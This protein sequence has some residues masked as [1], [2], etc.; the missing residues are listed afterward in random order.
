[1]PRQ[2]IP[3]E[4]RRPAAIQFPYQQN[5]W[6]QYLTDPE[7]RRYAEVCRKATKQ[8]TEAQDI[9]DFYRKIHLQST[10]AP[11]S[12]FPPRDPTWQPTTAST[13]S[14]RVPSIEPS[15]LLEPSTSTAPGFDDFAR[16]L[17]AVLPQ[18]DPVPPIARRPGTVDQR[19]RVFDTPPP[20]APRPR[21]PSTTS[22]AHPPTAPTMARHNRTPWIRSRADTQAPESRPPDRSPTA[23]RPRQ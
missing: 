9:Y 15:P 19:L 18:S 11:P 13:S 7:R 6:S 17:R 5:I 23:A 21:R 4:D 12:D 3:I 1:M 20:Q 16:S 2:K 10:Q 22:L 8:G 14:A